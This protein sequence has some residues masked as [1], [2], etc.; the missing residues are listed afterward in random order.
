MSLGGERIGDD[1]F[2]TP[3]TPP[4]V[5]AATPE[6]D[7]PSA[8]NAMAWAATTLLLT[9]GATLVSTLVLARLLLP[10]DFG[11]FAVGLLVV[12]YLDRVKDAGVG[13]ALIYR[14]EK[15][16]DLAPTALS[17]SV[18]TAVALAATTFALAPLAGVFFDDRAVG[19]VRALALVL[20]V[21]GLMIVPE[22]RLH[23][24][25]DFRRRVL[26]ETLTA[27]VK[28]A[29]SIALAVA[30]Y[31]VWSLV[32]G[33]LI[34]TVLLAVLYWLLCGWRPRFAW[35][36]EYSRLLL[37]YGL[38]S[39][40]V[41]VLASIIDNIDYVVIGGLLSTSD[42]G[43]YVLAYRL[44]E[45]SVTAICIVA[46]QVFFPWFSRLQDDVPALRATYLRAVRYVS[47]VTFPIG[48]GLAVVAPEVVRVLYSDRWDASIPLLRL[49]ALFSL[50]YSMGFH[51][52]EVYKSTGRPGILNTMAVLKVVLLVPVL[53]WAAQYGIVA[54]AWGVLGTNVVLTAVEL[55]VAMR[56]LRLSAVP[57]LGAFVPAAACSILMGAAALGA[58]TLAPGEAGSLSLAVAVAVAVPV[59]L[60]AVRVLVPETFQEAWQLVRR[61][62][63][64]TRPGESS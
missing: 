42:L 10:A 23:R 58:R 44:P 46:G 17:I 32:W 50:V 48:I 12:N 56:I 64:A 22:S 15:W 13:A 47:L 9:R 38:P 25:L 7:S 24:D 63:M 26:P 30:G 8:A 18:V 40:L 19:I 4:A 14:R 51:A 62:G 6:A 35:H 33:Q 39:A 45:L 34:G 59:Y 49:L 11:L 1:P 36:R 20:L 27:V 2:G 54:V 43:Y 5:Q 41:A 21:S 28:A 3:D 55:A 61:R 29:A 60:L 31:G 37:A 16:T 57:L 52:G 53:A